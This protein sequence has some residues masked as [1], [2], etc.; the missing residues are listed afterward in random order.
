MTKERPLRCSCG[1]PASFHPKV[2]SCSLKACTCRLFEP[3]RNP[4]VLREVA[5]A[6]REEVIVNLERAKSETEKWSEGQK[7]DE[8]WTSLDLVH[9]ALGV[10]SR[11]GVEP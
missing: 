6:L 3:I 9:R 5:D 4:E 2:Q 10:M 1:H 11:L 8:V 7:L